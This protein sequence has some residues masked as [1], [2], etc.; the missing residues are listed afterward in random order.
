MSTLLR[1]Q[2]R[3][4]C[5]FCQTTISPPPPQPL[6]FLCPHCSCW[7]RYDAN[8]DILSDDPAMHDESMNRTSFARRASPRKDRLLTTFGSAPFCTTCQSNQRLIVGL[9]SSY[10]PPSDDD[11]DYAPRL[12]GFTAYK[13]SI[14]ARYPPVCDRCAPLV[15]EE[16]RKKDVMARSNAL[17]SWLNESKKKD[18]R[19]QVFLSNMDRHKLNRELRWWTARGVLWAATLLGAVSAEVAGAVGRLTLP[20]RSFLVPS[21]PVFVLL[22]ILWTAWL[23]TY[24]SFRRAELQGRKTLQAA[25]WLVRMFT[26]SLIAVSW[27]RPSMDYLSLRSSPASISSRVFFSFALCFELF[28]SVYSFLTLRLHRA[29]SVRLIDTPYSRAS[30]PST[31]ATPSRP[32]SSPPP[33]T[34]PATTTTTA[35]YLSLSYARTGTHD[36]HDLLDSLSL[37]AAPIPLRTRHPQHA[38][39]HASAGPG[40]IFGHP[41]SD[42]PLSSSHH[43]HHHH[44]RRRFPLRSPATPRCARGT[45]KT[46]ASTRWIGRLPPPRPP[47]GRH[48]EV[49]PPFAG[50]DADPGG[51]GRGDDG[52]RD[53]VGA[54]EHRLVGAGGRVYPCQATGRCDDQEDE[55]LVVGMGLCAVARPLGRRH[56]LSPLSITAVTRYAR[57]LAGGNSK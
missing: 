17:G 27:H 51:G 9:L 57:A 44:H 45:T 4:V 5:F 47:C 1:R 52:A 21:L 20:E 56:V 53:V 25:A 34:A 2:T 13:T 10:L 3:I 15:E 11:P 49:L 40:P 8:G 42:R 55:H 48:R 14:Y 50:A 37:A 12:A 18:T 26:S 46:R 33:H 31:N 54:H 35:S 29:P 19:R 7:N 23:P 30:T 6:S 38:H 43:R 24:A 16:I 41:L 39:P 22:S 28:T 32:S 36:P